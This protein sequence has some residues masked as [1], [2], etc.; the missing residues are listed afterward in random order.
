MAEVATMS[1]FTY[2][3]GWRHSRDR[4]PNLRRVLAWLGSFPDLDV[5]VVEQDDTSRFSPPLGVRH[6]FARSEEP[7]NRSWGFNIAYRESDSSHI[8]F[9]DSDIIMHTGEFRASLEAA[10]SLDVVSPYS[11]VIDLDPGESLMALEGMALISRPGRG[12]Q[13]NQKINLCGG[14][15]IFSRDALEMVGGWDEDFVGWGGEDDMMT[16][17][18]NAARLKTASMPFRCFHLWHPRTEP[19]KASYSRMLEMLRGKVSA[20]GAASLSLALA[21]FG[22]CGDKRRL[23]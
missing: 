16:F 18:V 1:K 3:I 19:D 10:E 11:S 17:K 7:Y 23:F 2:A 13:D 21:S 6:V 8:V 20:G 9:G 4:E 14:I 5:L 12:E 22:S 15:V